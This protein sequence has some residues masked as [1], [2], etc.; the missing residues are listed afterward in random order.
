MFPLRDF[1]LKPDDFKAVGKGLRRPECIVAEHDG[2]LWIAEAPG[3]AVRIDPDGTQTKVGNIG[4]IP[5]GLAMDRSGDLYIANVG[6]GRVYKLHRDGRHDILLSEVEGQPIREA[7]NFVLL[8]SEGRLW[9]TVSTRKVPRSEALSNP[10][11]D[12]YIIMRNHEGERV[13]ADGLFFANE[14][15][16]DADEKYLYV[17]ETTGGGVSRFLLTDDGWLGPREPYGPAPIFPGA[18]IDG[19]T[20]DVDGNLWITEIRNNGIHVLFPNGEVSTVFEDPE[21]ETLPHPTSITF[22][23]NDL[24]TAYVGSLKTTCIHSFSSPVPG[25]PLLH[26]K[27]E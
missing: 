9:I 24:K 27:V 17:A 20:F 5:N 4:G 19:I 1:K 10:T 25:L 3:G 23:G 11:P 12:G 2:T 26:W 21:G 7:A 15:R 13:V 18:L 8:D 6:D 16:L 14:A 22:G